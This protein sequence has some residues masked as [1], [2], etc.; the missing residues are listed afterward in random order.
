MPSISYAICAHNEHVELER[1]LTFLIDKIEEEDE[2]VVQLD[3]TAT[4]DVKSVVNRF[5]SKIKLI[6]PW[7]GL[8]GDF[9]TFKNNLNKSCTKEY[10][11]NIDADELPCDTLI[12]RLKTILYSNFH[13]DVFLVPR[14]NT[15]KGLTQAH[16]N[17]WGWQVENDRINFPD[18]QWRIH[19]NKPNIKWENSVHEVLSGYGIFSALPAQDEYCLLHD[20]HIDRQEKQNELYEKIQKGIILPISNVTKSFS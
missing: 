1:L 18:Y 5:S 16:I 15:V 19:K 13:I 7:P 2:I 14:I 4:A 17:K 11:F 9:S 3:S 20:K 8:N 6:E 10:I 12:E